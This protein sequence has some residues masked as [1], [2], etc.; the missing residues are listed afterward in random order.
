MLA[1]RTIDR[2]SRAIALVVDDDPVF[3]RTL[4]RELRRWN[5]AMAWAR[6]CAEG[7]E[8]LAELAGSTVTGVRPRVSGFADAV[9]GLAFPLI[10]IDLFLADGSG[11]DLIREAAARAVDCP[12]V[13][14]TGY[15]NVAA[16]GA[17]V[18]AGARVCLEKPVSVPA[19]LRAAQD[20]EGLARE[21]LASA[22]SRTLA[23]VERR[24]I[25]GM[26]AE[27]DGSLSEAA[28]RLGLHRRTLQRMLKKNP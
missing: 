24:H 3:A 11:V 22:P 5:I 21:R 4:G 19:L 1:A 26:L 25:E 23:S 18:S 13:A 16:A 20:P 27:C 17:A 10:I 8:A 2:S 15:A 6:G 14:V 12:I 7:R 28:R 9:K